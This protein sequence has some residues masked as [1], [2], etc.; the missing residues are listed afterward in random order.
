MS[1]SI[2]EE[3][4]QKTLERALSMTDLQSFRYYV[5]H[6]DKNSANLAKEVIKWYMLGDH[7]YFLPNVS[8]AETYREVTDEETK[9]FR[10]KFK[11]QIKALI[12]REPRLEQDD[13]TFLIWYS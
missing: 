8:L 1:S 9:A 13:G 2:Q 7:G 11:A 5:H 3:N 4:K 6:I 12:K 10:D